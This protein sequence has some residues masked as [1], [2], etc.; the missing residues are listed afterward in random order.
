M[1]RSNDRLDEVANADINRYLA[2]VASIYERA[3]AGENQGRDYFKAHSITD[4]RIFSKHRIG[5]SVGNLKEIL[6]S[7]GKVIN[8]LRNIGILDDSGNEK[9]AACLT[10]PVLDANGNVCNIVGISTQD[11]STVTLPNLPA[12][13]WNLRAVRSYSEIYITCNII[14]ALSLEEAGYSN[15]ICTN[16]FSD[17]TVQHLRKYG[18]KSLLLLGDIQVSEA[19]DGSIQEVTIPDG[20]NGYLQENGAESLAEFIVGS[21]QAS[22]EADD[23]PERVNSSKAQTPSSLQD[24]SF[25]VVYAHRKYEVLGLEKG[26]RK[27]KA[28]IKL[29]VAGKFHV[30]TLNLYCSRSRK[31]LAQEICRIFHETPDAIDADISRLI[32]E[33]EQHQ[34]KREQ[35]IDSVIRVEGKDKEDAE[36]LGK[37]PE[38]IETILDDFNSCGLI[39]EKAN[40]LLCY[41]A[42]TSRKMDKPLS[43]LIL[44]SSGAGKSMMQDTATSF[45]PPEEMVKLTNISG[46]ALFYKDQLSLKHKVLALEEREGGEDANYAIRNLMS[47]GELMSE[48]T[49]KDNA[50]GK[51]TTMA[52]RVEGPTAVFV[53]TTNPDID[54]ETKSRFLTTSIDESHRQTKAIQEFQR[55]AQT[56]KG[57]RGNLKV[58]DILKRHRNFQRLLKPLAVVNPYADQLTYTDYRLQGRRDHP[59]YL[60]LIKSVCFLRQ[61]QKEVKILNDG[62]GVEYIEVDLKDIEIANDLAQEI[63][64]KSLDELS[65]PG[66]ELLMELDNMVDKW[67]KSRKANRT[68]IKFTRREI[69]EYSGWSNYRVHTHLKELL[70][71]EY[72]CMESGRNGSVHK[73][74]L[75]YEGQGKEGEKFLL[76]L[77]TKVELKREA[78]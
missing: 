67:T 73:Y 49:I 4:N 48:S 24:D 9:F 7:D 35:I 72:V 20:A 51:L 41:L 78:I 12:P 29:E 26:K 54:P 39:G 66:R 57:L 17:K 10:F 74:K 58:A 13:V 33:C 53:T 46:K 60:N 28:T 76:G 52:N 19:W 62:S 21:G 2:K 42:V 64:G 69:R 14:D 77:K 31:T 27:L 11:S 40:K 23:K 50:T 43:V 55:E 47:A 65:R 71:L 8:A 30:D 25:T 70:D 37:S 45:C 1:T 6:P 38:L 3:L 34:P 44:S 59:K 32:N 61:M 18:V 16:E 15:V 36:A 75:A 56:I 63:L 5:Y 68:D 22:N